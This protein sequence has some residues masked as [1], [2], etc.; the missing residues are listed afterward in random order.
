LTQKVLEEE[1][2][3]EVCL[4]VFLEDIEAED[5]VVMAVILLLALW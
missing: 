2:G 5:K 3:E 1:K 4:P